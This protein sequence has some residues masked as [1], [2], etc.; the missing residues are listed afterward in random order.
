[1]ATMYQQSRRGFT[2]RP[3]KAQIRLAMKFKQWTNADLA[4]KSKISPSTIGNILGARDTCNPETAGK[5]AKALGF[6]TDDLFTLEQIS[7]AA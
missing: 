2:A 5:I 1:M 7:Y 4:F 3:H 6:N